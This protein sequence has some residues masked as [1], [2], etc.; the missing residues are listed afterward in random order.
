MG[1]L[2][3]SV[4]LRVTW[5]T[6]VVAAVNA[7]MIVAACP[8]GLPAPDS[9][10]MWIA[11]SWVGMFSAQLIGLG[12]WAALRDGSLLGRLAMPLALLLMQI[13]AAVVG[14]RINSNATDARNLI[15]QIAGFAV[16][17]MVFLVPRKYGW[18]IAHAKQTTSAFSLAHLF[19]AVTYTAAAVAIW[20]WAVSDH[21]GRIDFA[22]FT[23]LS[24][25]A[26]QFVFVALSTLVLCILAF[27]CI[28]L[29]MKGGKRYGIQLAC[30]LAI[31]LLVI[32]ISAISI[33]S[34]PV[35]SLMMIPLS[36]VLVTLWIF[37]AYRSCGYHFV[38][39]VTSS[40]RS[41]RWF[42][43]GT[44]LAIVGIVCSAIGLHDFRIRA[45]LNNPWKE[46]GILPQWDDNNVLVGA[47][48]YR[49]GNG[50]SRAGIEALKQQSSLRSLGVEGSVS[51]EQIGWV[52]ELSGVDELSLIGKN[53]KDE[54]LKMLHNA[55]HL[56]QIHLYNT[57]VTV[58]GTRQLDQA[59]Q[60]CQVDP[61][62]NVLARPNVNVQRVK[63]R[64]VRE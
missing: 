20:T 54:H 30:S 9:A 46:L 16:A 36:M 31:A 39:H 42:L 62:G 33:P 13:V 8:W 55:M 52:A 15:G 24:A 19:L 26:E 56:Q 23:R 51:P 60:D 12:A 40:R 34:E 43:A 57:N 44:A 61:E 17:G 22:R 35:S 10:E 64:V 1:T 6:A 29:V 50:L 21:Q 2:L 59:L 58:V 45:A 4:R 37:T 38:G 27:P 14:E 3:D 5:V 49:S 53:I 41:R 18:R 7:A 25:V 32:A 47:K 48:F 28:G 11:F 63:V